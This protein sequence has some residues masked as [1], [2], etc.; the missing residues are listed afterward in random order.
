MTTDKS[1]RL[2]LLLRSLLIAGGLTL[3]K[4]GVFFITNSMAMLASAA[5][6]FMDLVVS[7]ANFALVRSAAKP[8][9]HQH[10]YGHGKFESLAGLAQSFVI[11]GAALGLAGMAVKRL[12]TPEPILQPGIGMA[13]TIVALLLNLWHSKNLRASMAATHSQVM[14]A[15]YLHYASDTLVYVGLLASFIIFKTTGSMIWD[16]LISLMIV[17]YLLKNVV[18]IFHGTLVELLDVQLPEPLLKEI[19]EQIRSFDPKVAG[20]HDLRTRK[21]GPTKFIEFHVVLRGV[22]TFHEAHALTA[23]I[24]HRLK[25]KYPGSVV[26][27]HADPA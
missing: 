15:E 6:S 20:Y 2:T 23:G 9:D 18:S 13:I 22:E 11:G 26:T 1:G 8:A 10:P 25:E 12:L 19:D 24:T 16:P 27:V 7:L 21:V 5:D 3:F 4:L 14:A 17:V